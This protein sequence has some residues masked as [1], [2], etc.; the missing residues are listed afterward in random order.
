[1]TAAEALQVTI[2]F[3]DGDP[4]DDELCLAALTIGEPLVD[5]YWQEILGEL[6]AL[7][8]E[9]V[10]FRKM[11]SCC[12]FDDAVPVEVRDHLYGFVRAED[13]IGHQPT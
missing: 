3:I 7:L 1:M 4:G 13:D 5:L 2:E 12:D 8:Q 10:E 9:R 11:V 6:I